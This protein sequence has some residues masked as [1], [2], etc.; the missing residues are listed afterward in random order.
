MYKD[1]RFSN[2][3]PFNSRCRKQGRVE[4]VPGELQNGRMQ[5]NNK[6]HSN[7]KGDNA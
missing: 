1:I 3:G 6:G 2:E 7:D 5:T 4:I